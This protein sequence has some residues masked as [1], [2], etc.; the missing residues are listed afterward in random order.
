MSERIDRHW[1][2]LN[3]HQRETKIMIEKFVES[4]GGDKRWWV[5]IAVV[6]L[7]TV[8]VLGVM[9]RGFKWI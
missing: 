5:L 2:S 8:A 4:R 9:A 3:A 1:E 7:G 6:L